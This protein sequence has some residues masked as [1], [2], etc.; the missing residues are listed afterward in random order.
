MIAVSDFR[1][2]GYFSRWEFTARFHLTAS[3][4]ETISL[5]ELLALKD[6][7][8]PVANAP[9]RLHDASLYNGHYYVYFGP[10]PV[11]TL[12]LPWRI[13]TGWSIPNNL[14]VILFLLAGYIFSCLLLFTLLDGAG[15][16]PSWLQKRIAIA[17]LGLCRFALFR[18]YDCWLLRWV[19]IGSFAVASLLFF[20]SGFRWTWGWWL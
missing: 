19:S 2:E 11:I 5:K 13:V 18:R 12:Y 20:L 6:P 7:W 14:A 15:V 1:L 16:Q 10:V 9:Y 3:D 4:A 8:D 17:A